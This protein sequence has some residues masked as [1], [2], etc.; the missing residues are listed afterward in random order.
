MNGKV[1]IVCPV[2]EYHMEDGCSAALVTKFSIPPKRLCLGR[3]HS[4]GSS[5][6]RRFPSH[7][8]NLT[9]AALIQ[10][11]GSLLL[12]FELPHEA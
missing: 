1:H 7:M 4:S 5:D 9:G 8:R 6:T 10:L 3:Q 12:L 2:A 11:F